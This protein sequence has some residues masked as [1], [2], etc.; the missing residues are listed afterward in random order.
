MAVTGLVAGSRVDG[1]AGSPLYALL[2]ITL[3]LLAV[4]YPSWG[5]V[6]MGAVM[7]RGLPG[8]R[9]RG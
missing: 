5:V 4:A 8:L 3:G 7:D 6:A 2:F 1:G 9:R